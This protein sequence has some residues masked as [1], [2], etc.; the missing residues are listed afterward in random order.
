MSNESAATLRRQARRAA[1]ASPTTLSEDELHDLAHDVEH[2]I[3]K[4]ALSLPTQTAPNLLTLSAPRNGNRKTI[5]H[6]PTP[7]DSPTMSRPVRLLIASLGNPPPY[8]STRHSA[9]HILLKSLA[10]SLSLPPLQKS[11]SYGNGSVSEGLQYTLYQSPSLMNVSG[12]PLLKAWKFFLTQTSDPEAITG[13]VLLHDELEASTAQLKIRRGESSARGHNGI[14]SV[15]ASF[16]A[17][18]ILSSL[19][20]SFIKVGVGIGRPVSREKDD[21]SA[22]V[23]GPI[24]G[25]EKIK[26]EGVAHDLEALLGKEVARMGRA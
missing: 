2:E 11:K 10:T 15:Q 26:I 20:Q 3:K 6:L 7:P 5:T 18:G 13:L 22:Y 17:G 1:S 8:H 19:G 25:Q 12:P 23:L 24:T 14:K 9:G 16:Q 21:V 4:E